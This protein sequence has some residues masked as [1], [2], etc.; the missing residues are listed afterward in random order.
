[1]LRRFETLCLKLDCGG[2]SWPNFALFTPVKVKELVSEMF[3]S[4]VQA[5]N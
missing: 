2:K 4:T 1:M 5:F 3:E